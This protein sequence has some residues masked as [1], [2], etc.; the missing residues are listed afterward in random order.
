MIER[1]WPDR[2]AIATTILASGRAPGGLVVSVLPLLR[3][4]YRT[5]IRRRPQGEAAAQSGASHEPDQHGTT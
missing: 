5:F 4:V 3:W 1:L 2:R